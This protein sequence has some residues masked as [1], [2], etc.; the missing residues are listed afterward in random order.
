MGKRSYGRGPVQEGDSFTNDL[1]DIENNSTYGIYPILCKLKIELLVRDPHLP[2][3]QIDEDQLI[4][5]KL[6]SSMVWSATVQINYVTIS[7]IQKLI[8]ST[9][10]DLHKWN[11]NNTKN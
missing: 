4:P 5:D 10:S 3:I 6:K 9:I 1:N 8:R 2:E 11:Q 7:S